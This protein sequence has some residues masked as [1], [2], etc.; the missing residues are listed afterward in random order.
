MIVVSILAVFFY[1]IGFILFSGMYYGMEFTKTK[2]LL[3]C[4]FYPI[5]MWTVK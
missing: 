5:T 3:T 4:I 2:D 1:I